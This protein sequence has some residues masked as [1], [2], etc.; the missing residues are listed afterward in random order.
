MG[1]GVQVSK[2]KLK[3]VS[4]YCAPHALK[5]VSGKSDGIVHAVCLS[6]GFS[7]EYG[8]EE[9]EWQKAAK[10]LGIRLRRKNLKQAELYRCKLKEFIQLH[11][12]GVFIIYTDAHLFVLDNG[13]IVDPLTE[14]EGL[15][16]IVTG[17]W[18]VLN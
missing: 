2:R 18:R 8:L 7:K 1:Q 16:R 10:E 3:Y 13:V 15:A 4:G 5:Y 6:N 12:E 9:H 14:G 11:P 17:A